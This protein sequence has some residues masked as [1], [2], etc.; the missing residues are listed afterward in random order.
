MF[1]HTEITAYSRVPNY[2]TNGSVEH[3]SALINLCLLIERH[4]KLILARPNLERPLKSKIPRRNI[5]RL[6]GSSRASQI[7]PTELV[8]LPAN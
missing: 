1:L 2:I 3:L 6:V 7:E 4:K 5:M 8:S